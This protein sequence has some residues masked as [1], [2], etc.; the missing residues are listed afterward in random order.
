MYSTGMAPF[1]QPA[2]IYY[3]S[4][5]EFGKINSFIDYFDDTDGIMVDLENSEWKWE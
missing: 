1:P 2:T 5:Y 4:E 3:R